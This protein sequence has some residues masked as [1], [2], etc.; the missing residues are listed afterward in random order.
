MSFGAIITTGENHERMSPDIMRY[1]TECRVEQDMSKLTEFAIR[2]EDDICDGDPIVAGRAELDPN[3]MISVF[4]K[5]HSK[6]HCLVSGR[7]TQK[8][9]SSMAGGA[10]S[11]VE[12]KGQ[13]D[14]VRMDRVGVQAKWSGKASGAAQSLFE[15]F[16]F[17]ANCQQTL[18]DYDD[19]QNTLNQRGTDLAFVKDIARK[20][21]MELWL[22][23]E[24]SEDAAA[25]AA[26][27]LDPTA[28]PGPVTV[29]VKAN[30]YTSPEQPTVTSTTA[31]P[32]PSPPVLAPEEGLV[33]PVNPPAGEC[34]R[35]TKFDVS[36]DYEK[37]NA[38]IGFAQD[39]ENG[40]EVQQQQE[41]EAAL[42][43]PGA[44]VFSSVD[45]VTREAIAPPA[46]DPDEAFLAQQA[47]LTEAAWFV[48]VE[49]SSTL[50]LLDFAPMPH[51]IVDVAN[52]G[53]QLSGPYQ[54]MS[55]THVINASD[56]FI[57]FNLRANG[58]RPP[59]EAA[60]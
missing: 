28:D 48:E 47:M 52:A 12:V 42:L 58:L 30:L 1:L 36:I 4:V 33:I 8:R 5:R 53:A 54:V 45:G 7:I 13:D 29:N 18:K 10:G 40:E 57:D 20:N 11:W 9:T 16:G 34:A 27:A 55:A 60:A 6:L 2:F 59:A 56:H 21:N 23:Y 24:A 15:L 3:A 43:D 38:S 39:L 22:S 37:P 46:T 19:A 31:L 41:S 32:P 51:Q 49:C 26:I 25:L 35:L 50:D 17:E 44:D 14:L